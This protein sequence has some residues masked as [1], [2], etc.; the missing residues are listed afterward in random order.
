MRLLNV[1]TLEFTD[2]HDESQ[3]DYAILSHRWGAGEMKYKDML[4][5]RR[6]SGHGYEKITGFAEFIK[7]HSEQLNVTHKKLSWIWVDT[8]CIVSRHHAPQSTAWALRAVLNRC[9]I[10]VVAPS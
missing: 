8:C 4:K 1:H 6:L 7:E 10:K 9:R 3:P 2:F 5:Q